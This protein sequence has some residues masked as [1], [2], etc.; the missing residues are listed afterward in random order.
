M[1]QKFVSVKALQF[2]HLPDIHICI[3]HY[4]NF[5]QNKVCLGELNNY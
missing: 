5:F 2:T 1:K 4:H 3:E